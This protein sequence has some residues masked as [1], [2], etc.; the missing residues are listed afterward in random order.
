MNWRNLTI[1][2]GISYKDDSEAGKVGDTEGK[3]REEKIQTTRRRG[4]FF[5]SVSVG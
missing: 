1:D 2:G 5:L 3:G 4:F